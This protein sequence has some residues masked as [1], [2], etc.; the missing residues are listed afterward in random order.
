MSECKKCGKPHVCVRFPGRPSCIRHHSVNH[1]TDP[2]GPCG[3]PPM[4]GQKVCGSHGGRSRQAKRKA[5]ERIAEA[6]AEKTLAEAMR[7]AYGDHVPD[8]P[9]AEAMLQAVSWT[10]AEVLVL[11][12]KV[13]ELGIDELAWGVTKETEG[14]VV[15]G[16]GPSAFLDKSEGVTR[17]AKPNV[18]WV[19][20][21]E[22]KRDLVKF[23]AAARAAGCDE[24]RVQLAEQQGQLVAEVIRGVA[25]DLLAV[26][27]A[28]GL[29]EKLAGVFRSALGEVVPRRLRAIAG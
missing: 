5:A 20:L 9:P 24:R 16:N 27:V 17:E 3:L 26:L 11:R 29:T 6:K 25:D 13:A 1:A 8:V 7:D 14:D 2:G 19:M 15:V 12:R 4:N 22:A 18:W 23:A 21:T 10:H 28:A